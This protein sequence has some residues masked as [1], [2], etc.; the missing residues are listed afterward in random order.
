MNL[1]IIA[2][3]NLG[4]G[5]SGGDTILINF[6][7]HWQKKLKITV[8]ASQETI[9]I[10]N[11][12]Q[13]SNI[14]IIK[15]DTK[16]TNPNHFSTFNILKHT[17]RRTI[18]GLKTAQKHGNIINNSHFIY[19]ASDFYPDLLPA[20]YS[21]LINPKIKWIAGYYLLAPP[22]FSHSSPYKGINKIKGILYWTMQQ[23]SLFIVKKWADFVLVTSKP[24]TKKFPHKK[25]IIVQGGVDIPNSITCKAQVTR[26]E[27]PQYDACFMGRFH[28]QKGVLELIDIWKKVVAQKP[29][30]KLVMIGDGELMN[31]VKNKIKK[32]GLKNNIILTGFKENTQTQNIFKQSKM[33]LHPAT[34]DSGG[35]S[36]AQGMAYKLPA[37]SFDLES[38]K[39]YYPK[40]ILKTPKY[41][42][43]KFAQNII[44]LLDNPTLYKKTSKDAYDLIIHTWDWKKRTKRIYQQIFTA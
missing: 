33:I 37:V 41:D 10:F 40:G 38:L 32:L 26:R 18:K 11:R 30:A 34:F 24:D 31:K 14:K 42:L 25:V 12:H 19:S 35:M 3:N 36:A 39:T 21:K 8:L 23:P 2:N 16:N 29:N 17:V 22:P 9:N 20:F 13:L 6:I 27:K 44:K 15:T 1:L 43:D 4:N 5:L 28:F 7:K